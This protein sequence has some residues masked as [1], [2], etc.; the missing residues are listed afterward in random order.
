MV[1]GHEGGQKK[2]VENTTGLPSTIILTHTSL[3]SVTFA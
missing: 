1:G 2:K 3:T